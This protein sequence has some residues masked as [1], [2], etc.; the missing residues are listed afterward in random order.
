MRIVTSTGSRLARCEPGRDVRLLMSIRTYVA[1]FVLLLLTAL[2]A[3]CGSSGEAV[4]ESPESAAAQRGESQRA[5]GQQS[6]AAE[7]SDGTEDTT[8]LRVA[9]R[10]GGLR[11]LAADVLRTDD[12]PTTVYVRL[13]ESGAAEVLGGANAITFTR[14]LADLVECSCSSAAATVR[15]FVETA[16]PFL[17][18]AVAAA[19]VETSDELFN[20]V[21]AAARDQL[22]ANIT[23]LELSWQAASLER[24]DLAQAALREWLAVDVTRATRVYEEWLAARD[25]RQDTGNPVVDGASRALRG[26]D[27]DFSASRLAVA[28]L[29]SC[30]NSLDC[31]VAETIDRLEA[32]ATAFQPRLDDALKQ[33][34]ALEPRT[35]EEEDVVRVMQGLLNAWQ[36]AL[37]A[38]RALD[39]LNEDS[40]IAF[41][42]AILGIALASA[43]VASL[44]EQ[45]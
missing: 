16:L 12:E 3:A 37:E 38:A 36:R 39:E 33:L 41:N 14:A 23:A 26:L 9:E 17:E 1:G 10:L 40:F 19:S 11:E 31:D 44:G 28:A 22:L 6:Q 8:T 45:S 4:T 35:P 24:G 15:E 7:V 34:A 2:S 43:E 32:V 25:P 42:E 21:L 18:D 29:I 13:I 5:E 30:V 27:A 20:E